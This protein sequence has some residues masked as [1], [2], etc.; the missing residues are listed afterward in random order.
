MSDQDKQLYRIESVRFFQGKPLR[1]VKFMGTIKGT[2]DYVRD[3]V[4]IDAEVVSIIHYV[5][6]ASIEPNAL[7]AGAR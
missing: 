2:T 3:L 5:K 7:V 1:H 4:R 6:H